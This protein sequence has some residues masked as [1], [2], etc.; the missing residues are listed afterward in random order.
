MAMVDALF[1]QH[2][3]DF[4]EVYEVLRTFIVAAPDSDYRIEVLRCWPLGKYKPRV[5]KQETITLPGRIERIIWREYEMGYKAQDD[6]DT[7][8]GVGFECYQAPKRTL[9]NTLAQQA[10]RLD[11]RVIL[12]SRA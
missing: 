6:P 2:Q 10:T 4:D 8:V 3:D 11:I 5:Y 1:Q 12:E 9:K 7:A